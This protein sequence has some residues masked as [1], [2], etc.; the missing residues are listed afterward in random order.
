MIASVDGHLEVVRLL[1]EAGADKDKA[2]THGHTAVHFASV[3][4]HLEV[5]RLLC[6]AGADKDQA[7]TNGH[8]AFVLGSVLLQADKD[9]GLCFRHHPGSA[10]IH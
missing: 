2:H 3:N 5:V 1:C 4:G 8:T 7:D 6:E 9:N 10:D